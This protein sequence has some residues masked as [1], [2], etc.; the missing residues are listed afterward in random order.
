MNCSNNMV[1]PTDRRIDRLIHLLVENATVVMPGPRI[2]DEMGVTRSTV[3]QWIKKL[4]GLGLEIRGYAGGGYQIRQ[5]PDVLTPSLVEAALGDCEIGKT[6]LH[7]ITAGSTNT[8]ALRLA[9]GGAAHGTVVVAE[10]QSAGRGRFGRTWYSEKSSGIYA[11][12]ILRPP[13]AP[14][15]APILTLMAGLAAHQAVKEMTGLTPDIRWPNDIL[16]GGKKVGGIL[17][18]MS[19]EMDRIHA[20][21]AGIGLNV[22]HQEMPVEIRV[23]ATSLRIEGG[24]RYSRVQLLAC[25]LRQVQHFY[26][27]LLDQGSAAIS[28][29]WAE[30]STFARGKRVRVKTEAGESFALTEGVEPNGALRVRFNDGHAASLFSGEV[31]E[32]K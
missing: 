32:I 28:R 8:L 4:R 5:L 22:N 9:A 11:S 6:I 7:Y 16:V 17:T 3:W 29:A 12:I 14:S 31:I 10:E 1:Q 23:L 18:E 15:A 24:R 2:A 25:L 20:V 26:R 21:V 19:A 27:L 13:V 30:R